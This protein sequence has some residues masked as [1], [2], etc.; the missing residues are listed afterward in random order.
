MKKG[1][2]FMA[3]RQ[4]FNSGCGALMVKVLYSHR[5]RARSTWVVS[6]GKKV[7]TIRAV[8]KGFDMRARQFNYQITIDGVPKYVVS[9][10]SPE[11]LQ[12]KVFEALRDMQW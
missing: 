11:N 5:G 1:N 6:N 9:V 3:P 7:S 4:F 10:P 12:K 2:E 8:L